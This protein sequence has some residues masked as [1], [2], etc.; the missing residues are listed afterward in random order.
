MNRRTIFPILSLFHIVHLPMHRI[1]QIR[2]NHRWNFQ[3]IIML[4][5]IVKQALLRIVVPWFWFCA[6]FLI[7]VSHCIVVC[8]F[9]VFTIYSNISK[10][11]LYQIKSQSSICVFQLH[12]PYNLFGIWLDNI[13]SLS[14]HQDNHQSLEEVV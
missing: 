10:C 6:C 9:I 12:R 8:C 3:S 4:P 14:L 1:F 11:C 5:Y 2:P 7:Y 13:I